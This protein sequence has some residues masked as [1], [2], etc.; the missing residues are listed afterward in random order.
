[1]TMTHRGRL[2]LLLLLSAAV[3]TTVVVERTAA[4]ATNFNV[5][6]RGFSAYV[7]DG[8]NNARLTLTRGQTYTFTLDV[9]GHPFWITTALGAGDTETNAFSEGVTR[10]GASDGTLTFVV[11]A[12]APSTLFYQ[13]QFHDP[14][15]GTLTIISP[16][17]VP[18]SGR[19]ASAFLAGA[20][21]LVAVVMGRRFFQ[22][23][24]RMLPP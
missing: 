11:P 17:P 16:T 24:R 12:T 18:S 20:L 22:K 1:M 9:P 21:L 7:V 14:M 6:A 4:A 23:Q 2:P 19:G 8:V 3:C 13:C 5:T 10:N 15:A